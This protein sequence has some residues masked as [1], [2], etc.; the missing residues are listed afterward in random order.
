M[1]LVRVGQIRRWKE[2]T[3]NEQFKIIKYRSFFCNMH[4]YIIEYLTDG[5]QQTIEE[6]QFKESVIC[7]E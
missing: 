2:N 1:E 6:S 7:E 4:Y 5:R 3:K